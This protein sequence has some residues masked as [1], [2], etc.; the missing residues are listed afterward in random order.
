MA[1]S[2]SAAI[3]S[4]SPGRSP[5]LIVSRVSCGCGMA[6]YMAHVRSIE[7]FFADADSGSLP[8]FCII[9]PDFRSYSE[10]TPQ[11]IRKGRA[12]PPR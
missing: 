9:D 10:E 1:T 7:R 3:S 2:F 12:L 6:S 11:D 8:S 5:F 4:R